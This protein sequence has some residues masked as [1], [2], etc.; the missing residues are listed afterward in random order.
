MDTTRI[1]TIPNSAVVG[2]PSIIHPTAQSSSAP[3]ADV[4]MPISEATLSCVASAVDT[5]FSSH[6]R[7]NGST[8]NLIY[9]DMVGKKLFTVSTYPDRAKEFRE[10]PS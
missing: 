1:T 8:V 4:T 3:D 9:G 6:N 2:N 7:T 10:R 5:A